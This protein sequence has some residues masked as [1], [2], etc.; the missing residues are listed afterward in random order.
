MSAVFLP[1][2]ILRYRLYSHA[3]LYLHSM[4]MMIGKKAALIILTDG[5]ASD[6]DI[7]GER[8]TERDMVKYDVTGQ[9]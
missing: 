8:W 5:E 1:F 9:L 4:S 6:G 7:V 2:L 3:Y